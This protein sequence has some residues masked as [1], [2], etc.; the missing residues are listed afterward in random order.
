[1]NLASIAEDHA[2]DAVAI[3][4]R[5]VATTY[6]ELSSE[7][8][9]VRGGLQGLGLHPGDR[10]AIL[11]ANNRL[12]V[13]SY[14][15]VLGAG[16][17]AVPMNPSSPA[18]EIEGQLTITG[19]RA[20]IVGPSA[21]G[22]FT[23]ALDIV[24]G[25]DEMGRLAK[26][27]PAPIVERQPEDPAVLIFTA[28]TAGAPKAATL[29]H[30][31]LHTN[32]RQ[33][34]AVPDR[35]L[36]GDDVSLG[37]LPFFHIFGLNVVLGLSLY[38]GGSVV[39]VERFDPTTA[40]DTV[41]NHGVT[42]IAGAPPMWVAWS[43][44]PG[45]EPDTFRTV[46]LALSGAAPLPVE[47]ADAMSDRFGVMVEEGYGLT[48]ASPVVTTFGRGGS[49]GRPLPGVSVRLVGDDG[50]DVPLGDPGEL[51]VQGPNVFAGYW[52]D[53]EATASVLTPD[54]WLRSGDIAVADDDGTLCIV[55][56]AK[57]LIIVSGFNVFP[58]EVEDALRAHPGVADAAV[59]G[60]AHPHTGEAVK[61]YVVPR[62]GQAIEE[63]ELIDFCATRLARYKCPEKV[64]FVETL[65]LN[66][67]GK[68]LR[69]ELR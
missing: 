8:A 24:L 40:L 25:A 47:V 58:A 3:V 67:G 44:M 2:S 12:F 62:S 54:G 1:V 61:A 7:V 43:S 56:R 57:D 9:H 37:V 10:V 46:R 17:V 64:L 18:T 42:V 65:P 4:S 36:R 5:G 26:A 32:L 48:E 66:P 52:N 29:T 33:A 23:S 35:A 63:D 19:A 6:G 68:V 14:L 28:G 30:G 16:L 21:A 41:R 31:S 27:E 45:I 60:V 49:I 51:W 13:V 11:C 22:A 55:D 50:E 38:A 34:Q 20:A 69:R 59:I 15:A 53:P 39:L